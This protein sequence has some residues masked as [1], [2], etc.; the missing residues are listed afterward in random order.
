MSAWMHAAIA[1]W[2]DA[3]AEVRDAIETRARLQRMRALQSVSELATVTSL[4][5]GEGIETVAIKGP[6]FARWLY[7]DAGMRR[8]ADLDLVIDP[9]QRDAALRTLGAAGY[10]L[11]GRL[12]PAAAATVFA[13]TGAWPLFHDT[14]LG[15]DLHW[16]LQAV[17][18]GSPLAYGD[19][20]R[21]S[22]ATIVAGST[23][24]IPAPTH[25]AALALLHAAKHLWASLELVLAIAH[26]V[27][28][29][30]VDWAGVRDVA[31][32]A[33]AWRGAA[34]GLALSAE[35]FAVEPPLELRQWI[36]PQDTRPLVDAAVSFL[37]MPDVA[38]ASL[39]AEIAAHWAALDGVAARTRYAAWRLLAPTP[40]EAAWWP[41][42]DRLTPLYAPLRL[43]RLLTVRRR[44]GA[45]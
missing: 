2:P 24:R 16:K 17:G 9:A 39:R 32:R 22:V 38:G 33:G 8:L 5:R 43:I 20:V 13:G 1:D 25:A 19:V 27:R 28:R 21:E 44:D 6:M 35:L 31:T 45:R 40:L 36:R 4:L 12:T 10:A 26:L 41:L 7:G 29:N 34:A 37:A 14:A 30:D 3:P 15:I 42:P 18:F 23:I 11:P